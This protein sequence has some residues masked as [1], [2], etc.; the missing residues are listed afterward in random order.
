MELS[1]INALESNS[2][3]DKYL[4]GR[5]RDYRENVLFAI[6][7][8]AQLQFQRLHIENKGKRSKQKCPTYYIDLFSHEMRKLICDSWC[9]IMNDLEKIGLVES[10]PYSTGEGKTKAGHGFP[11]SYRLKPYL[12]KKAW[13]VVQIEERKPAK[14]KA[15][16]HKLPCLD[17]NRFTIQSI[18]ALAALPDIAKK[19][20]WN[21]FTANQFQLQILGFAANNGV[22]YSETGRQFNKVNALP[23]EL[24]AFVLRD[25]EQCAE[26]DVKSCAPTLLINSF[27]DPTQKGRWEKWIKKGIFYEKI[28]EAFETDREGGKGLFKY[29]LGGWDKSPLHEWI[30]AN[31]PDLA[32]IEQNLASITQTDESKVFVSAMKGKGWASTHDGALVPLSELQTAKQLVADQFQKLFGLSVI[33]T[34]DGERACDEVHPL[35]KETTGIDISLPL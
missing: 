34:V 19:R 24:R 9:Q 16:H 3:L 2:R 23:K 6:H 1:Y 4:Q 20:K 30:A 27:T 5:R 35:L 10:T 29:W 11:K 31:F 17:M 12:Y 18:E 28:G 7:D 22:T 14:I 26:I 32:L 13:T 21:S 33:V 15:K 25:G 8:L